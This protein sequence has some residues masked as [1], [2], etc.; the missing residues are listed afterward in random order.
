M[1]TIVKAGFAAALACAGLAFA[2]PASAQ[3]VQ[4]GTLVCTVQPN[5]AFVVGSVRNLDCSLRPATRST[6][7]GKYAGTIRRF[8]L[9]IGMSGKQTLVWGVLAPTRRVSPGDLAGTYVG[10]S[11]NAAVGVGLGANAL[12]GGSR[13]AI[14][15]QPI[16][17][18]GGTGVNLGLTVSDLTLTVR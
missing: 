10:A 12:I 7:A 1:K 18:E 5:V 15:L 6:R 16:S 11:A 14:T 2:A 3:S 9:D 8:G 13:N 17:V 4:I